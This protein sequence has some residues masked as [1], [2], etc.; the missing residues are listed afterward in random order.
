MGGNGD[1][2][3]VA[4]GVAEAGGVLVAVAVTGISVLVGV[5]VGDGGVELAVAVAVLVGATGVMVTVG[6]ADG[7]G[8]TVCVGVLVAVAEGVFVGLQYKSPPL[9]L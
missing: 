9:S 2:V 8:A 1:L 3:E 7:I 5:T 6:D 4:I